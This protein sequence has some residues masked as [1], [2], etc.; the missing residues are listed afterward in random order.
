MMRESV[1]QTGEVRVV[2]RA[3]AA[4]VEEQVQDRK[5]A[6]ESAIAELRCSNED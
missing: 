2:P 6:K 1:E 5:R 3:D 4:T